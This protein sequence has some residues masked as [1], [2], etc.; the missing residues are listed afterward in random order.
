MMACSVTRVE[1][2]SCFEKRFSRISY[3]SLDTDREM[4]SK[5]GQYG[6]DDIRKN[7]LKVDASV[8]NENPRE[9]VFQEKRISLLHH[10]SRHYESLR[11]LFHSLELKERNESLVV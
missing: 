9:N 5:E 8:F 10:L 2:V 4:A 1:Y 11:V 3:D 7:F 6:G